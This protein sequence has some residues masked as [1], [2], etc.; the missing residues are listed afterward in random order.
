MLIAVALAIAGYALICVILWRWQTHLIFFP[1]RTVTRTPADLGVP[2]DEIRV[3]FQSRDGQKEELD[4]FWL[5][6]DALPESTAALSAAVAASSVHRGRRGASA[7]KAILYLHG[8]GDNIG[9]NLPHAVLL[10]S[11][12]ISVLLFD[13]RGYGRSTGPSPSE[14]RV[15]EDAEIAWRYLVKKHSYSPHQ[16]VIY[17]H[18]LGGAIAI[19]LAS[20]HPEAAGVIVES[21]L[22]SAADMARRMPAFWLFP[23][24][25]LLQHR[26]DSLAKI[27]A[28]RVPILLLH[29]TR[30]WSVP[31]RMTRRLFAAASAPK[32][33]LMIEGGSHLNCSDVGGQIYLDAI[34][35]FL[36]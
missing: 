30:D 3:P 10:R 23:L 13:Y 1:A 32:T 9:V 18:S 21:S 31:A 15:Y 5:P 7:P 17:G 36:R 20:R 2:G 25:L 12:G 24:G 8:N 19:E 34:W 6:A 27:G 28:L 29:G 11:L 33:M 14:E 4:A 16:I 22:T 26:F 35:E